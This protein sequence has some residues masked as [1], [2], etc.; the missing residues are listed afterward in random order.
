MLKTFLDKLDI[1]DDL[2]WKYEWGKKNIMMK[3]Y[4]EYDEYD[5]ADEQQYVDSEEEEE[6]VVCRGKKR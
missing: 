1:Q 6:E 3:E 4:D 5:D 2:W